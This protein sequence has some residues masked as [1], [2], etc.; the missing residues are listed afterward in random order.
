M[1][2]EMPNAPLPH[3][4]PEFY[5]WLWFTSENN[6]GSLDLGGETGTID[7]WVDER[8]AFQAWRSQCP[9]DHDW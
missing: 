3:L 9:C 7:V 2:M 6:G 5:G 8:L 4:G 1:S